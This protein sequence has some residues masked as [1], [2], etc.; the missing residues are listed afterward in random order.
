[1]TKPTALQNREITAIL[2]F[3]L[4]TLAS[5]QTLNHHQEMPC[6]ELESFSQKILSMLFVLLSIPALCL[7]SF[8]FDRCSSKNKCNGFSGVTN[9]YS[10]NITLDK[11]EIIKWITHSKLAP[12]Q[13]P[14][15]Q[16]L[17]EIKF[18][19]DIPPHFIDP[20][21]QTIMWRPILMVTGNIAR[22]IKKGGHSVDAITIKEIM[23]TEGLPCDPISKYKIVGCVRNWNLEEAIERWVNEQ[24]NKLD[25]MP[26]KTLADTK[27]SLLQQHSLLKKRGIVKEKPESSVGVYT[28]PLWM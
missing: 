25:P 8:Y 7:I 11:D 9:Y 16:K 24:V 23:E 13:N 28:R 5:G 17:R 10:N 2:F 26:A 6:L 1:M 21:N 14:H 19:G 12:D 27:K 15:E 4:L 18:K 3:A 20:V 22:L